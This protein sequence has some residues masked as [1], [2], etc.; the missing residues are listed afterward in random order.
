MEGWTECGVEA[1]LEPNSDEIRPVLL[2]GKQ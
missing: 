1:D 2:Q